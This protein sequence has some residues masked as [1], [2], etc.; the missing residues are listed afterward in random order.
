MR[1]CVCVHMG[2]RVCARARLCVCVNTR[3]SLESTCS[4]HAASFEWHAYVGLRVCVCVDL[5]VCVCVLYTYQLGV[6]LF[7][8]RCIERV[9]VHMYPHT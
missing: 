9:H 7:L 8:T 2:V 4:S 3:T 5:R 6:Y 1:V